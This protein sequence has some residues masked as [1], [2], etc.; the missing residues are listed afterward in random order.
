MLFHVEQVLPWFQFLECFTWNKALM[1]LSSN[2]NLSPFSIILR[3]PFTPT[4][5]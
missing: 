2:Y 5:I 3:W 4:S 1:P